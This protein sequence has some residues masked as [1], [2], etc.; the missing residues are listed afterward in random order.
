MNNGGY[1]NTKDYYTNCQIEFLNVDNIHA[2]RDSF[3]KM[4]EI[5]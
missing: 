4:A 1:E 3:K 5:A 2:V